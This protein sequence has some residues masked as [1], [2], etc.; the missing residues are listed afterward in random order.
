MKHSEN[1]NISDKLLCAVPVLL[2]I[3]NVYI[4][5]IEHIGFASA[6]MSILLPLGIYFLLISVFRKTPVASLFMF[7]VMVLASFQIV[8]SSLYNDGSAIG[9]DMFLN[10][11]TTNYQEAKELLI[12]LSKPI[13][14]VVVVYL[15]V[16]VLSFRALRQKDFATDI[17][18]KKIRLTGMV[19]LAVGGGLYIGNKSYGYSITS[20]M[21]PFNAISNLSEAVLR[22]QKT[23]RYI[24]T[25]ERFSYNAQS[26]R[27]DDPE[28]YIAVIGETS[29]ADNWQ[30][31]GYDR[32]TNPFLSCYGDSLI[33]FGKAFSES[34]TTHK[35]VPMMLT[36]LYSENYNEG[37]YEH[38][39]I[40]TAFKKAGFHTVFLSTQRRNHSFIEQYAREADTVRF[41]SDAERQACPDADIL[42]HVKSF[43][44]SGIYNKLL[45]MIHLYGSHY[46]Y[47]DRYPADRAVFT[48]DDCRQ[49]KSENREYLVNA[50]DNTIV[51]TDSI[52]HELCMIT[53]KSG[54][55]GA[56]IYCSD[57]GEDIYD[58][59]GRKFLHASPKPTYW[60]LHIPFL[61]FIGSEYDRT[62][63]DMKNNA[64]RNS[65][66]I[67]SS[68]RSFAQ[69]LL[70]IAGINT[71]YSIHSQSVVND[72]YISPDRLLFLNDRNEPADLMLWGF[73]SIDRT[74]YLDL[75]D[76]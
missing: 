51:Y 55:K 5:L 31:S 58:D 17:M 50:Y 29:R 47:K 75:K 39:S 57:H 22:Y 18:K 30:L 3:P 38:K 25:S 6:V 24:A 19:C 45:I 10:V 20:D 70:H 15:P 54:V 72:N 9:I 42:P 41:F 52:L 34:N 8:V 65:S 56:L 62:Y 68:S 61:M 67:I 71:D 46:N 69:T 66:Q 73:D 53:D 11:K 2:I 37:I 74:H 13:I 33:V 4:C 28:L 12:S 7:P 49:A 43:V 27:T 1:M 48:P 32:A 40:I 44:D 60:Q 59:S 26:S 63:P 23:A 36:T 21:F 76:N 16:I 35:S 14:I 64:I